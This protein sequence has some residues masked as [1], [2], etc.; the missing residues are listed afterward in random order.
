[1]QP[2]S[3]RHGGEREGGC[4]F[5]G[6]GVWDAECG[7]GPADGVFSE[8]ATGRHHFVKRGDAIAGG[9]FPDGTADGVDD[10][11]DVIT[12]VGVVGWDEV[13]EFPGVL[14]VVVLMEDG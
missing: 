14:L 4:V 10:A 12:R 1:M 13:G 9:E 5:E 6:E 8:R 2:D 7:P 11:G 3:S